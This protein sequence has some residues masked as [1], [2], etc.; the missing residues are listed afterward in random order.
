MTKHTIQ[1]GLMS[2]LIYVAAN[3]FYYI[4]STLFSWNNLLF[5]Q[6]E[7]EFSLIVINVVFGIIAALSL[8]I[9]AKRMLS[10]ANFESKI[11]Y[12]LTGI[13]ISLFFVLVVINEVYATIIA[14]SDFKELEKFYLLDYS[15]GQSIG[16]IFP[17]VALI[18]F[19]ISLK[20]KVPNKSE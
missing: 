1:I 18:Y 17:F 15:W 12:Q 8:I 5:F 11:I 4:L 13:C 2:V 10:K 20:N 14:K 19:L 6:I 3:K 16:G 7:S 9:A